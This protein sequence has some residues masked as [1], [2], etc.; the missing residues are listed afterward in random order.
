[1]RNQ[2]WPR[3]AT[4]TAVP[5]TRP[6]RRQGHLRLRIQ[7]PASG[8]PQLNPKAMEVR[9]EPGERREREGAVRTP[10][11][12][13]MRQRSQSWPSKLPSN[14]GTWTHVSG[15]PCSRPQ[16]ATPLFAAPLLKDAA[17][18]QPRP[19]LRRLLKSSRPSP[20]GCCHQIRL[21]QSGLLLSPVRPPR[22][23]ERCCLKAGCCGLL[24]AARAGCCGLLRAAASD[25]VEHEGWR[26]FAIVALPFRRAM[27]CRTNWSSAEAPACRLQG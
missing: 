6:K 11:P 4:P 21:L 1:M 20:A 19:V 17:P 7:A 3:L 12:Q 5:T 16:T 25:E 22:F 23:L 10:T 9:R 2:T 24:P 13:R 18:A 15:L 8:L 27:W 14:N 26:S